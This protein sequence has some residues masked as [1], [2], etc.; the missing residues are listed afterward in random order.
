MKLENIDV[1]EFL[2]EVEELGTEAGDWKIHL[3]NEAASQ[4]RMSRA[5][6]AKYGEHAEACSYCQ[7]L[8]D[9]LGK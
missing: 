9:L 8:V 6:R 5:I 4:Y 2:A 3:P 7:E 1:D